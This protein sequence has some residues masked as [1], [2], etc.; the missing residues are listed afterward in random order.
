MEKASQNRTK[1]AAFSP[2]SM[3]SVPAMELGWFA[4]T[5]TVRPSI[6]PNPTTML[7]E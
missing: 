5:P 4:T 3:F 7:G 2:A 6:R 1:R